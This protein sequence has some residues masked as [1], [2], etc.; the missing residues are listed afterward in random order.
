MAD[1]AK[2][3]EIADCAAVKTSGCYILI[4]P[5]RQPDNI[6]VAG[7]FSYSIVGIDAETKTGRKFMRAILLNLADDFQ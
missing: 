6:A 2:L 5:N 7:E 3:R 4:V 1:E